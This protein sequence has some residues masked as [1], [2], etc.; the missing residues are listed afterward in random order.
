MICNHF[1]ISD[2]RY[3]TGWIKLQ[4]GALRKYALCR[5][6]FQTLRDKEVAKLPGTWEHLETTYTL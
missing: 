6:C 2:G 5:K 1:P 3:E 4:T